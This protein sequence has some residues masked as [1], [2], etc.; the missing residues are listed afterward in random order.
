MPPGLPRRPASSKRVL[1]EAK[2]ESGHP[3]PG[4]GVAPAKSQ[5]CRARTADSRY[6]ERKAGSPTASR[7]TTRTSEPLDMRDHARPYRLARQSP[8]SRAHVLLHVVD[9]RSRWDRAAHGGMRDNELEHELSPVLAVDLAR[10]GGQ[11]VFRETLQKHALLEGTIGDDADAPIARKW[12][13]AGLDLAVE[14]VVGD[15]H[16]V[17]RMLAHDTLDVGVTAT[18]RG[19]NTDITNLASRLLLEQ[20]LEVGFPG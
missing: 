16:E 12:K 14:N 10:P 1:D 17:E 5:G 11:R 19:R 8:K 20:G 15:L 18:F 3:R 4:P 2:P 6:A 13:D 7:S 9:P